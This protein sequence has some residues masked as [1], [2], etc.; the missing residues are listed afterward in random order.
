METIVIVAGSVAFMLNALVLAWIGIKIRRVSVE[1]GYRGPTI[2]IV[3]GAIG[4]VAFALSVSGVPTAVDE[5]WPPAGIAALFVFPV[6]VLA[7]CAG[8]V[9]LLPRRNPREGP[10]TSR[11][12]FQALGW[13]AAAGA[14]LAVLAGLVAGI[15]A[16]TWSIVRVG[17]LL[18][19][20]ATVC[21]SFA[22]RQRL[23]QTDPMAGGDNRSPVVYLRPFRQET[24][25][26]SEEGSRVNWTGL[27]RWAGV[28]YGRPEEVFLSFER[29]VEGAVERHLGPFRA[30]GNPRDYLPP[31]GASRTYAGEEWKKDIRAFI[32]QAG[33]VLTVVAAVSDS[34]ALIFEFTYMLKSGAV[35]RLFVATSP[36]GPTRPPPRRLRIGNRLQ[37]ITPTPWRRF[38]A[39]LNEL[40][41]KVPT[42]PPPPGTVLRFDKQGRAVEVTTGART[43]DDYIIPIA[44]RLAAG[45][46]RSAHPY[47]EPRGMTIS[48]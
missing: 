6:L 24:E 30:L 38:A 11:F 14:V 5:H 8:L 15:A 34:E 12:P 46:P 37:G 17:I 25:I 13:L 32:D 28:F 40:G 19:M 4:V 31:E 10:R 3:V 39:D 22:R 27:R 18:A 7:C 16:D 9:A 44:T 20:V 1:R 48:S 41:Y 23:A 35:D 43:P 26:F 42:D 33:C 2:V 36:Y 29:F 45:T 21:F 47:D